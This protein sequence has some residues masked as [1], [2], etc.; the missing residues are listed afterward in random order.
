MW[1]VL[2][3]K[4]TRKNRVMLCGPECEHIATT[5]DEINFTNNALQF[6][7][8]ALKMWLTQTKK[9]Q[10]ILK[11]TSLHD[12]LSFNALHT[13]TET[14]KHTHTHT[15]THKHTHT[16]TQL[17]TCDAQTIKSCLPGLGVPSPELQEQE[18]W[19]LCYLSIRESVK[20]RSGR[21]TKFC[22]NQMRVQVEDMQRSLH[23]WTLRF[24]NWDTEIVN[25]WINLEKGHVLRSNSRSRDHF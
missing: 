3:L 25:S 19:T 8:N 12:F 23:G 2:N 1:G 21:C 11:H 7:N 9:Q 14:N 13:H 4:C 24:C 6:T 20:C 5:R 18:S 22:T 15:R 17:E 16:H 10:S